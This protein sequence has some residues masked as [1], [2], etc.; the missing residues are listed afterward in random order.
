M[1]A[2]AAVAVFQCGSFA[3]AQSTWLPISGT[4]SWTTGTAWSNGSI[5][6]STGALAVFPTAAVG[7][8]VLSSTVTTGTI[9]FTAASGNLVLAG[10]NGLIDDVITL[11]TASG[12]PTVNVNGSSQLYFYTDLAGTQGYTKTGNGT[13][14]FR[15]NTDNLSYTG[16]TTLGGGTV[17]INQDGSLGNVNNPWR[18]HGDS[19]EAPRRSTGS[20]SLRRRA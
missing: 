11:A 12:S 4:V 20:T 9:N 17:Q 15:Y 10:S 8:S 7:A 6:N 3:Y 5:P 16:T 14:I 1:A 18:I 19:P 13:L 2:L